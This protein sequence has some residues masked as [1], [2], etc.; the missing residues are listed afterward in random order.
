[1]KNGK[2]WGDTIEIFSNQ[3]VEVHRINANKGGY[4][5]KHKHLHKHN[6]FFVESGKLRVIIWHPK[7]NLVDETILEP[8]QMTSV[9]PGVYHKFEAIEST[10]AFEFYWT[11]ISKDDIDREDCG[12]VA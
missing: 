7:Y 6:L 12:G 10:I 5:S 4:S 1:M 9:P 8:G 11:E 2:V 3:G